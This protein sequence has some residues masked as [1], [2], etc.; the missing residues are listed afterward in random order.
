VLLLRPGGGEEGA[1]ESKT[2]DLIPEDIQSIDSLVP[3]NAAAY[4]RH[5]GGKC[6]PSGSSSSWSCSIKRKLKKTRN[7]TD[8]NQS[9]PAM[10]GSGSVVTCRRHGG[11]I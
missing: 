10:P 11:E 8:G 2:L 9:V 6:G 4:A 5:G 1:V 3:E 7:L